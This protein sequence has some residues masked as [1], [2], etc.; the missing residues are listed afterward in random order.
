MIDA[1]AAVR[2]ET[3]PERVRRGRGAP[4]LG[5]VSLLAI[6]IGGVLLARPI[7]SPSA[8]PAR[9]A[10]EV[11]ATAMNQARGPGN[12]SPTL[13]DDPTNPRFVVLAN[14]L[15]APDFSCALQL[16][17]DGG[18]KWAPANPVPE[19]PAGAEKCYAPEV[20]FDRRGVLHYLFVGLAGRGNEPMGVF[21]TT[22]S[23]RGRTFTRPRQVL[24]PLRFAVR[25]GIDPTLG[26]AG[27]LHLVWI[28]ATSD[29]PLGGFGPPPNPILHAFSDDGG[30]KFSKPVQI[31]DR[32]RERVVA[33]ALALGP[34]HAVHVAY[35]DLRDDK[36][37]YQGLAGPVWEDTW[38]LVV[39][40]SLD[41]G[42]SFS[43]G[44]V[45]E[46]AVT[47]PERVMLIFTMAPPSL[48]AHGELLCLAWTDGRSGDPD[49]FVRCSGDRGRPW[50]EARRINDDKA[51]NGV[52]QDM[53]RL[54]VSASG[55]LDA[56]FYDRRVVPGNFVN[57][58]FYTFSLDGG[59]QWATNVK[60]TRDGS[61]SR[62]GQQYANASAEGKVE[63]GSRVGLISRR[64]SAVAAWT[65]TRNSRP[66]TAG[67]DIFTA[68]VSSLP[69]PAADRRPV[70]IGG[71]ALVTAG[72]AM[73]IVSVA[74][75]R[76]NRRRRDGAPDADA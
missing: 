76:R 12:N 13:L 38:S 8:A 53:P 61:S 41:G 46:P 74:A 20:A 32:Q 30:Q 9:P 19:L 73:L 23:D 40:T 18:H 68:V 60:V 7:A 34:D 59:R 33:P 56:I 65:D 3:P 11:P 2:V 25:M 31:S 27:R 10:L 52:T 50:G 15:D 14:R 21:L 64:E 63:F 37:D 16:S 43:R 54:A 6:I 17:G 49:A 35:Y 57:D 26:S 29:P 44:D 75:A 24:G 28:E 70:R 39:S 69:E 48:V 55:R 22:S 67:Q 42:R 47:P 4:L 1:D 45:A 72:V 62:I 66:N 5:L 36:L 71:G 58:V 51:G